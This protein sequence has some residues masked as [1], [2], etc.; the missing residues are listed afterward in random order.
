MQAMA[1]IT[2]DLEKRRRPRDLVS[3]CCIGSPVVLGSLSGLADGTLLTVN[4][5]TPGQWRPKYRDSDQ[6]LPFGIDLICGR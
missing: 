6:V 2:I 4:A 5:A 3:S 1:T